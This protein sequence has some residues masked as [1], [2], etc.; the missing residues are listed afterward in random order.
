M[1]RKNRIYNI[2]II[3]CAVVFAVSAFMLVRGIVIGKKEQNEFEDL[4]NLI[5]ELPVI[6]NTQTEQPTKPEPQR[7]ISAVLEQNSECIGWIF[8]EG[9][10]ID[11]P[12]MYTPDNPEKYLHLSF[13]G[14]YSF[15]GTPFL[16]ERCKKDSFNTILYGHNMKNGTMFNQLRW[17]RTLKHLQEHP[18]IE[19]QTA[20]GL[21]KFVVFAAAQIKADDDWYSFIDVNSEEEYN[22][23]IKYLKSIDLFESGKTPIY[24]QKLITLSTCSGEGR[25]IVVG[26]EE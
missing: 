8:V 3:V 1:N 4:S 26:Y 20:D 5:T 9:T 18:Y 10:I 25:Y 2:I 14:K 7:D 23:Q 11:Y 12:V 6:E 17:Y 13:S 15:A 24:P 21:R 19:Y 16:E 22:K